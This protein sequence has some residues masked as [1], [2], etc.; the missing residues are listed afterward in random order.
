MSRDIIATVKLA[1]Q[2]FPG[3]PETVSDVFQVETRLRA[4]E[5]FWEGLSVTGAYMKILEGLPD[6]ISADDK[7]GI[8]KIVA[9]AWRQYRLEGGG[10]E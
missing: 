2:Y 10:E 1:A 6:S 3:S 7:A 8:L 5:F 4:E 9:K